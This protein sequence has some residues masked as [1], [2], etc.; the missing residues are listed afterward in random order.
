MLFR[1]AMTNNRTAECVS[2]IAPL[3]AA[4]GPAIGWPNAANRFAYSK[5]EV[6]FAM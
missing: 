5:R 3:F 2:G 6:L 4:L 1:I